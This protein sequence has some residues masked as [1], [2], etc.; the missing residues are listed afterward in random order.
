MGYCTSY[1]LELEMYDHKTGA[2]SM[3]V[4]TEIQDKVVAALTEFEIIGYA[5]T[6][7][8]YCADCVKWYDHDDDM[9]KVSKM[10]P[11]VLFCL[12]GEGESN[13]D[14]WDTYYL[15]GKTQ[16]CP[17]TVVYPP[18]DPAKLS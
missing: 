7:D 16:D 5:L 2:R 18:F 14:L 1:S 13:D 11:D 8:L 9:I 17:A 15:N 3:C 4:P 12:H 10:F 6:S